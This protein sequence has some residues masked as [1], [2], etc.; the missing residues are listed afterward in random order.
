I[1]S[2]GSG[3]YPGSITGSGN[4]AGGLA[5]YV[6]GSVT[7]ASAS[8][9]VIGGRQYTGGLVGWANGAVSG[10]SASGA[11]QGSSYTGG[12]VGLSQGGTIDTSV[13]TG[14]VSGVN[15]TGG[16]VGQ[17]NNLISNSSASGM[18]NGQSDET[19]GLVGLAQGSISG[20]SASGVVQGANYTG[21]L[22]GIAQNGTID[23]SFATGA[24]SGSSRIGGLIGQN[25]DTVTNSYATVGVVA[26]TSDGV[27]GFVGW[28]YGN[29]EAGNYST[30]NVTATNNN[31][32]GGFVGVEQGNGLSGVWATG[33]VSGGSN[34]GGFAGYD[35]RNITLSYATGTVT[36]MGDGTGG[37]VGQHNGSSITHSYAT[38]AV[39][40]V[41][42]VG[43]FVGLAYGSSESN[44][45]ATGNVTGQ[46]ETGGFAGRNQTT[47]SMSYA[48]GDVTG[49]NLVGGF[50][51]HDYGT[52]TNSFAT[53]S[54]T[55]AYSQ[56]GGFVGRI[57]GASE[58]TNY[59]TG[60]VNGG[61]QVGGYAGQV[62]N[63]NNVTNVYAMGAVT[64]DDVVGGLV[65]YIQNG[66]LTSAFATGYV[67]AQTAN[68]GGL[69][70]Y[71]DS[72]G[73]TISNGYWNTQTT[74][75]ATGVGPSGGNV[76]GPYP[77]VAGQTT[78]Q[79]QS[80]LPAGFDSSVWSTGATLYPYLTSLFP[81][82]PQAITG[83]AYA[84][85]GVAAAGGQ[86]GLYQ[87][88]V[89]LG[90]GTASVGADGSFYQLTAGGTVGSASKVGEVLTL[91]G[92][93]A[94]SAQSYTEQQ[95]LVAGNVAMGDITA[96]QNL[97]ATADASL[98]A[99]NAD[100]AGVYGAATAASLAT[101][102]D[103]ARLSLL[104]SDT[105]GFVVDGALANSGRIRIQTA[106]SLTLNSGVSVSSTAGGDAVILAANGSF[107]NNA[108]SSAV[109]ASNGRWLIYSQAQNTAGSAPTGTVLGGLVG[110][111][112]YGDAYNFAG[113]VF[114]SAP[115]SGDRFVYGYQPTLTITAVA[116]TLV[117]NGTLQTDTYTVSGLINGDTQSQ[118]VSGVAGGLT[119][120]SKAVGDYGLTP[121][122]LSSGENYA[123]SYA[124]GV[125]SISPATLTA[126][127]IGPVQKTYDGTTAATIGA[128]NYGLAGVFSGDSVSL[129]DP[130]SGTYDTKDAGT[131]KTVSVSGLGLTG[132]DASDY[133]LSTA[134][135][136]GNVG[137]VTPL[138]LTAG[139]TGAVAKVYDGALAATLNGANYTLS[140]PIGADVVSL[141]PV[142]SGTYDTKDVGTGKTVSVAGLTLTG[143][144][145]N[146]YS[147]A[148]GLSGNVGVIN[149]LAISAS[150][151][152][153][154]VKTYDGTT[155]A[156]LAGDYTLNGVVPA[157]AANL[158][159]SAA[160]SAYAGKDV[161]TNLPVNF[162]GLALSG[163][164][165]N[166]Y[167]VANSLSGNVG[168]ITPLALAAGLTGTVAKTYDGT[169]VATLT[170]ANYTLVGAIA[171]DVVNLV[172]VAAGTYDSK[173]VGTGKTV[174]VAGLALTGADANDYS[175]AGALSGNVGTI[176]PLALV[177]GLTGTV[178][179]TYDGTTVA[180]LTAA[181]YTLSAAIGPDVVSLVP[182]TA[183]TY[184]SKDAGTGKTVS[185]AGLALTGADAN[186]YS[187]ATS[188]YGNVG[189]ITPF[190]LTASLT[191][192]VAKVYDGTTVAGLTGANYTL[193]APIGADVVALVPVTAGTYD[194]KDAG[195]G[196]TVSVAGLAL[197]GADANNYSLATSLYGNVG[198][199]TPLALTA[200][201]T[202]TVAKVYD[203]TT[204]ASLGA[205][206]Y[207][208]SAPIGADVV[209]LVPVTAGTYD[210]KD[211][212]TGKTV[213]VA[214]LGLTGPDA[215]DYSVATLVAGN[216]G[217]VTP[218]AL[219]A[220]LT[221][222]V[223]KVY[224]GTTAATLGA[225][226]Y[227][228]V[229]AIGGDSVALNDAA[230]GTYDTKDT[231]IGK[232]VS[233]AGLG[234]TGAEAND[235]T[236]A[237]SVSGNVGVVTPLALTAGLIGTVAKV[238]DG[239]TV[240]ALTGANYTLVGAIGGDS[241]A[242]ND[243][244]NGT[245]DTKDVGTG[246]T[247]SVA[248]LG[249]T[250]ANASDYSI[251]TSVAG[252]VG[253]VTAK[254]LTATVLANNKTYDATDADTGSATLAV[255]VV[256]GDQ[257]S[258]TSGT[259]TF[260]D[261]N[262]GQGKTVEVA[263]VTLAGADTFDYSL[264]VPANTTANIAPRPITIAANDVGKLTGQADPPLTYSIPS[265]SLVGG[266]QVSG[267][268]ARAPGDALG[269][270]DIG[271]GGLSLSANY[272]LS[273]VDGVFTIAPP[274]SGPIIF[275][276]ANAT[277][278][279]AV[280]GPAA[281]TTAG[282]SIGAVPEF[283]LSSAWVGA[284]PT[285]LATWQGDENSDTPYPDNRRVSDNIRFTAGTH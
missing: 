200:S 39:N 242:L 45:Y 274:T 131:G 95:S 154:V 113:G 59:E 32:T 275:V 214:G 218:L 27:G 170:G 220:G 80:T 21:G 103:G 100:L 67:T 247:V 35:D 130:S 143:A 106:G 273:F 42:Y 74:G 96:G 165:A 226:N 150:L 216:V 282:G 195:T 168:T 141:V 44:D 7:N 58:G 138:A 251:A 28:D 124:Q 123:L 69:V 98:S 43:G 237:T 196:K 102:L 265:G 264:S 183:G 271:Q 127:L 261:P 40:G 167:S 51:G 156:S 203:G 172:P 266:D 278:S 204:A 109:S 188:L 76:T 166:D 121:S 186:N 49:Q 149:P 182:V 139:L 239:T 136:S 159:L 277:G 85:P 15:Q 258:L 71:V 151:T 198:T 285:P 137:T 249:L 191:G 262:A 146:D 97:F 126:S 11:V 268:P 14:A 227:T 210:S 241:V 202:G 93:S 13:A 173:D 10:S 47:I 79:L 3:S 190:G 22:V 263:G 125:L 122:G 177:A 213:S 157:D 110:E 199:I 111:N 270:Y 155:A 26:G 222:T 234:L 148:A 253:T 212:G 235:Y 142:T 147:V 255:G 153:P 18:V 36:G 53:G 119:T 240:A 208:L 228:L 94:V 56:V 276:P 229:G 257:L 184:D 68:Q 233:V 245:Y 9:A 52:I 48:T 82:A 104:S 64:G 134:S 259:Y 163:S 171:G 207:T 169:I 91:L 193:S 283:A 221:G 144:D 224:D 250:G 243:A 90:Y 60:A 4:Y 164:A 135:L 29:I 197:S 187:L 178:A 105:S 57:D 88:G 267:T 83:L 37:F 162:S 118:A 272:L 160:S 174:S 86:V 215:N 46:Y 252:N 50:A 128:S 206:N 284:P 219:T 24:V 180:T 112:Y 70:G 192:T 20:S 115:N 92:A 205:G 185:V 175:I 99:M 89:L 230:S 5:G 2:P 23:T 244:A 236:V 217:S 54:V 34:V 1:T 8:G 189:T 223:A 72:T 33:N 6:S 116:K 279:N 30:R 84:N 179:K 152:G 25:Q 256:P 108:G 65:G 38:G 211:A 225:G 16:L 269:S 66:G 77:G 201:L 12:L 55:G 176:T 114:A 140:A 81:T 61:D 87:G 62:V 117:Y 107:I 31:Y 17:S 281:F 248:G 246:K 232:T 260:A 158:G 194:T 75:Q 238:Y 63:T 231:G 209:S 181:N 78:A 145:A 132:S 129:N 73:D 161:G 19:G 41:N 133:A 280:N 254:A 120:S 101:S